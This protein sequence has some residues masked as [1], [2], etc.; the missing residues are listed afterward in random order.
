MHGGIPILV[1]VSLLVGGAANAEPGEP[2]KYLINK[3]VSMMD[4][5]LLKIER[6]LN[7]H[8]GSKLLFSNATLYLAHA[9]YE[10]KRDR[11][12]VS[13]WYEVQ[14][15]DAPNDLRKANTQELK[16]LC[17]S[18]LGMMGLHSGITT[19]P[20]SLKNLFGHS[21]YQFG[22]QPKN[23]FRE[24]IEYIELE[25]RI[26]KTALGWVICNRD[27]NSPISATKYSFG[28]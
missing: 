25:V 8:I 19:V 7:Q 17:S 4:L 5:A 1:F 11:I 22:S 21:G 28:K 24:L 27:L 15:R 14:D 2:T 20:W 13:E 6:N 23:L 16:K 18:A 3:P 26:T 10:W 9:R 12:V